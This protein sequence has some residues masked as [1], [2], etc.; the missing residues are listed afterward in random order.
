MF[1]IVD[2]AKL[3]DNVH[4]IFRIIG[5]AN[6]L[7]EGYLSD[8]KQ[9]SKVLNYKSKMAETAHEIS[10]GSS[11]GPLLFL[12]YINGLQLANKFETTL[13]ADDAYSAISHKMLLIWNVR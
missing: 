12:L 4:Y 8:R 10:Q 2:H 7:L 9:Y 11:L 3:L 13:F 1:D 5:I 6:Q